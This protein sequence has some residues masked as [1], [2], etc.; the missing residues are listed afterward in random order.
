MSV[1]ENRY[2]ESMNSVKGISRSYISHFGFFTLVF[3]LFVVNL[4]AVTLSLNCTAG[5]PFLFRVASALYAFM[6]GFIY[7]FVNYI[8]YRVKIKDDTCFINI[9]KPFLFF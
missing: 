8:N 7:I 2:K 9:K 6:F 1:R 5:D 4:I 3:F